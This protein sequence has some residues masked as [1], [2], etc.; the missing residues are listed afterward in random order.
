[1]PNRQKPDR[2][3]GQALPATATAGQVAANLRAYAALLAQDMLQS[4]NRQPK[5]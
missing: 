1:M 2:F 4:M 3:G 5:P